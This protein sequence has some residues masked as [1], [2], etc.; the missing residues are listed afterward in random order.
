[1]DLSQAERDM[2]RALKGQG[3]ETLARDPRC[4]QCL[5]SSVDFEMVFAQ[6]HR[7]VGLPDPQLSRNDALGFVH[8]PAAG[9]DGRMRILHGHFR[10]W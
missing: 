2:V 5:D 3:Q 7:P 1:M 6:L 10:S 9:Q 8:R 4:R